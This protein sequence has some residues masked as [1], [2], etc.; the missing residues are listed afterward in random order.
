MVATIY[1]RPHT[2]ARERWAPKVA[3]G[4]V[5][6]WRCHARITTGQPW[7]LGHRDALPSA[8]EHTDCNRSAGGREGARRVW[9]RRRQADI[10]GSRAW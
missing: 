9:S 10:R 2:R 1:G 4:R 8:P 7:D 6:C 5:D 3:A